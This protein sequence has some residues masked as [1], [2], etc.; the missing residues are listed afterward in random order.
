MRSL[1]IFDKCINGSER[2]QLLFNNDDFNVGSIGSDRFFDENSMDFE[3]SSDFKKKI[4][5]NFFF[6]V[7]FVT[8]FNNCINFY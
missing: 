7:Y 3:K 2:L 6:R 4:I 5:I 8:I 1:L